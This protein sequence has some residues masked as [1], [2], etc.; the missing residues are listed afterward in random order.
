MSSIIKLSILNR[1]SKKFMHFST[2]GRADLHMH[3]T[4]SDGL[5]TAKALL[6]HVEQQKQLDVIAITDHDRLDASLWAYAHRDR[7]SFDI[8]PG[9][10]VTTIGGHVL[11][12]WVTEPIPMRMSLAETVSAIH[13]Q[14]GVAVLAHPFHVHMPEIA[15]SA[16]RYFRQP[17]LLVA[18]GFDGLEVHNA[19]VLT[20]GS[21]WLARRFAAKLGLTALGNSDAHT[22][23]AIGSGQT[24]F[25][26]RTAEDLRQAIT[27]RATRAEG[28]PWHLREY[29][30][31][32]RD[33]IERRGKRLPADVLDELDSEDL[34]LALDLELTH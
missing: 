13:E 11:A 7:Y 2:L 5:S 16:Q 26:G 12:L 32:T 6:A 25:V 33:L 8:V 19:G 1:S 27:D 14:G 22:L 17:Q 34:G 18:W 29:Y 31:Y 10:E 9:V 20:P 28:T 23:G 15:R 4:V 30:L 21:N 24:R 3:T